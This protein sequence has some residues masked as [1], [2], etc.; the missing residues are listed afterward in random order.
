MN[1][2]DHLLFESDTSGPGK[3][4]A[5]TV[6]VEIKLRPVALDETLAR[7]TALGFVL[8][9]RR[10]LERNTLFDSADEVLRRAGQILRLREYDGTHVLTFKGTSLPGKH[11]V[12]EEL[13]ST[14][15]DPV[16]FRLLLERLGYHP[17]FRYEKYRTVYGR[18]GET[19]HLTVDET[20]IGAFLELEGDADWID[21][22]A[23][24]LGF[25]TEQYIT[26][27]YGQLW[28]QHCAATGLPAGDF[29]FREPRE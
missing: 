11:K 13:E 23:A 4:S 5:R 18:P 17:T 8:H 6:E 15:G 21:Q 24:A 1:P 20:P 19:G 29:L 10:A 9:T 12:R 28:A 7:A 14:V 2:E 3:N 16:M 27:S 26:A 25:Q 22:T